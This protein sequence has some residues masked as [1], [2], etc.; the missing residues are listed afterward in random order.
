MLQFGWRSSADSLNAQVCRGTGA[1]STP[2]PPFPY[3]VVTVSAI[4]APSRA[5]I[6]VKLWGGRTDNLD[7]GLEGA[8]NVL[9]VGGCRRGLIQWHRNEFESR[10]HRS[11]A[12]VGAPIRRKAPEFFLVVPL[13]FFG[14]KSISC[15]GE[16]FRDGQYSL[17]VFLLAVFLLMV[18]LRARGGAIAMMSPQSY[19]GPSYH[20][21]LLSLN[22]VNIL[23]TSCL[24]YTSFIV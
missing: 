6:C 3:S 22:N 4:S 1:D 19:Y 23:I 8:A 9:E 18:P 7:C 2:S 17:V 21:A 15:F 12:K 11:G 24:N 20:A 10:G 13:H 16:C 14:P 5:P